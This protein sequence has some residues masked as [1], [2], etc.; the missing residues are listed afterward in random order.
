MAGIPEC[1]AAM[2]LV[3]SRWHPHDR[4]GVMRDTMFSFSGPPQ[5]VIVCRFRKAPRGDKS[6]FADSTFAVLKFCPFCKT[7]LGEKAMVR[8]PAKKRGRK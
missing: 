2:Q 5:D 1:C 3:L 6:D 4:A 8:T 7:Q